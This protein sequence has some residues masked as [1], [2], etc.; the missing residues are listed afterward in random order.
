[1]RKGIIDLL[2]RFR[3]PAS[4][5]GE[6]YQYYQNFNIP[7]GLALTP[8]S[9]NNERIPCSV[10]F[11][12]SDSTNLGR[13]SVGGQATDIN[14]GVEIG[15]GQAAVFTPDGGQMDAQ[16]MMAAGLGVGVAIGEYAGFGQDVSNLDELNSALGPNEPR[17]VLNIGS[18]FAIA[19][20]AAQNLR[21]IY[22][23]L[24]RVV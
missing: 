20:V 10:L 18:F 17:V 23:Q 19:S 7:V 16:K 11:V 2:R 4:H 5:P 8:L 12:Q 24:I 6:F 21:V 15:P 3:L 14:N 22:T 1:M 9:R 13:I